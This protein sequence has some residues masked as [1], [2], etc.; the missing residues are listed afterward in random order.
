MKKQIENKKNIIIYLGLLVLIVSAFSGCAGPKK[1]SPFQMDQMLVRAGFQLH[2]AETPK[3]LDFLKTMPQNE[4]VHKTYNEKMYYFY[5]PE[6]SCQC[7]YVGDEQA[8]QRLKQSV[9][10]EQMDERTATTSDQVQDEMNTI[11]M[12][13]SNPFN[14]QGHLP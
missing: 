5:A 3:Q 10:A 14:I 12:D 11:D 8:Y 4:I 13:T 7:V 6:S 2:K 1:I 9:K